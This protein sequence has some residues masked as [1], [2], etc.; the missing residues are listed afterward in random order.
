MRVPESGAGRQITADA[1]KVNEAFAYRFACMK[2]AQAQ[3]CAYQKVVLEAESLLTLARCAGITCFRMDSSVVPCRQG[4]G[5]REPRT[6]AVL[7]GVSPAVDACTV[8]PGGLLL[9]N[10]DHML[11]LSPWLTLAPAAGWPAS[12]LP[13]RQS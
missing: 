11:T 2:L 4:A 3:E 6:A 13:Q 7:G 5:V 12:T 8:S 9:L 1:G 10:S